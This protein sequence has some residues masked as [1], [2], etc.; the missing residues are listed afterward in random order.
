MLILCEYAKIYWNIS[1]HNFSFH[2]LEM[3]YFSV[4]FFIRTMRMSAHGFANYAMER[5]HLQI[6]E[7]LFGVG[8][9]PP[10]KL[11]KITS[12]IE[13]KS[14]DIIDITWRQYRRAMV[15]WI[16]LVGAAFVLLVIETIYFNATAQL[17]P[18]GMKR[19]VRKYRSY[20]FHQNNRNWDKGSKMAL[21][22]W[23]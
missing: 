4:I 8:A 1:S 15:T 7:Q 20:N 22:D 18:R 13:E 21:L 11:N 5:T 3:E 23:K 17:K 9:L 16:G 6:I 19:N 2:F 14:G 12:H 10:S